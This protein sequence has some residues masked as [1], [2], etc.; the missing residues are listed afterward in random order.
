M[1][2][3]GED[4]NSASSFEFSIGTQ[5]MSG[6][7][8]STVQAGTGRQFFSL[9]IPAHDSRFVSLPQSLVINRTDAGSDKWCLQVFGSGGTAIVLGYTS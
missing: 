2:A 7:E 9:S 4:N 5:L 3:I 6:T 1:T 8:C